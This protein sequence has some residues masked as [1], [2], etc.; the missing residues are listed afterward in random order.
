MNGGHDFMVIVM[1]GDV[2]N[3]VGQERCGIAFP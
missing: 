2:Q 1:I 3:I